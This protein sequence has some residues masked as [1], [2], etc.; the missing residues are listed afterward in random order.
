MNKYDTERGSKR[1]GTKTKRSEKMAAEKNF[2]NRLK[3]WLETQG[4]YALGTPRQKMTVP[5][6]GYW[7][8]RWG[9]GQFT[10]SGLPDMH[11]TV[12]GRSFDVE[13]KAPNG[14]PSELQEY[15]VDQIKNSGGTALILYPKDFEKFK[16]L[17][18]EVKNES[19]RTD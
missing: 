13:L 15:I 6:C 7:E 11:I 3:R 1:I 12:K 18:E 8:K 16:N 9:G 19:N 14:R 17:I 5:P 10:K 4:V 2:E